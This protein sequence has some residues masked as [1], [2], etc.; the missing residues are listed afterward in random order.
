MRHIFPAACI[1]LI[2]YVLVSPIMGRESDDNAYVLSRRQ[3]PV[4]A[5]GGNVVMSSDGKLL[6]IPKGHLGDIGLYAVEEKACIEIALLPADGTEI[7]PLGFVNNNSEIV[8]ATKDG[9]G[10]IVFGWSL[11]F[12]KKTFVFKSNSPIREVLQCFAVSKGQNLIAFCAAP[13]IIE[14]YNVSTESRI[15]VFELK[16]GERV[17]QSAFN[18]DGSVLVMLCNGASE[19]SQVYGRNLTKRTTDSLASTVGQ[20]RSASRISLS[21]CGK[22]LVMYGHGENDA[23]DGAIIVM[24][25]LSA[26]TI[27]KFETQGR[28]SGVS[29]AADDGLIAIYMESLGVLE[30]RDAAHDRVITR[31]RARLGTRPYIL[32]INRACDR[33]FMTNANGIRIWSA[34][35]GRIMNIAEGLEDV[36]AMS[37]C[38]DGSHLL[39]NGEDGISVWD[40]NA[41]RRLWAS[42]GSLLA[43]WSTVKGQFIVVH[44]ITGKLQSVSLAASGVKVDEMAWRLVVSDSPEI[45]TEYGAVQAQNEIVDVVVISPREVVCC[46]SIGNVVKYVADMNPR[47]VFSGRDKEQLMPPMVRY[48]EDQVRIAYQGERLLLPAGPKPLSI[49]PVHAREMGVLSFDVRANRNKVCFN[50][51]G[52]RLILLSQEASHAAVVF[53]NPNGEANEVVQLH[54]VDKAEMYAELKIDA[55]IAASPKKASYIGSSICLSRSGKMCVIPARDNSLS[56][57][58]TRPLK[59]AG[60]ITHRDMHGIECVVLNDE[61]TCAAVAC[62]GGKVIVVHL[63]SVN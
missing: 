33:V 50:I 59:L 40:V 29:L 28:V 35:T 56:V 9:S 51:S 14:V 37:F 46:D 6:A 19:W 60:T 4:Q 10:S 18:L 3:L 21:S 26:K 12:F 44:R 1:V 2:I 55:P 58:H 20:M 30:V 17:V 15:D 49:D 25:T 22:M 61:G 45:V 27:T 43:R 47:T 39:V 57:Y 5:L 7:E 36:S 8:C 41:K 13:T 54:D 52:A 23:S 32:R 62:R 48:S 34:S 38:K 31:I 53:P 42:S 16:P 24:D 11:E 63:P